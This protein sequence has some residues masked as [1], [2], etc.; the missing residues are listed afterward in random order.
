MVV[1]AS[2][3]LLRQ[4]AAAAAAASAVVDLCST[5]SAMTVRGERLTPSPEGF[6][7]VL[8]QAIPGGLLYRASVRRRL[9]DVRI[10]LFRPLNCRTTVYREPVC[11]PPRDADT[12]NCFGGVF[13]DH[14]G[15]LA[16]H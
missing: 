12:D 5:S 9:A 8:T 15:L 13:A 4:A 3:M 2:A 10:V 7:V 14:A 1:T 11:P 16:L 6:L